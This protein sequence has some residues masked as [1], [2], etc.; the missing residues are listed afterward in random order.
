[1]ALLWILVYDTQLAN[2]EL[3]L[4]GDLE[5]CNVG[6]K[7]YGNPLRIIFD[8]DWLQYLITS[9]NPSLSVLMAL[10]LYV[11][12]QFQMNRTENGNNEFD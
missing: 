12:R 9:L 2:W 1:M 7:S 8:F 10:F 6:K 5:E 3:V 11:P 4:E